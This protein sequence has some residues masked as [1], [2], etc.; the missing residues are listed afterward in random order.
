M[1]ERKTN[2]LHI[3]KI[4]NE[5]TSVLYVFLFGNMFKI[6]FLI[7]E[8]GGYRCWIFSILLRFMVFYIF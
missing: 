5:F 6:R 2:I 7:F 1:S 3:L 8:R 4:L